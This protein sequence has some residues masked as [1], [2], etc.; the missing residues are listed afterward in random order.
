MSYFIQRSNHLSSNVH[1]CP[2]LLRC[3]W[4]TESW[5]DELGLQCSALCLWSCLVSLMCAHHCTGLYMQFHSPQD[6]PVSSEGGV[7][8]EVDRYV[9]F[10]VFPH[11]CH[12][13]D[14]SFPGPLALFL[15]VQ[16]RDIFPG[17]RG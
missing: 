5:P 6:E 4:T 1:Y 3:R 10:G 7:R 8:F 11:S 2:P 9:V 14:G 15:S 13:L 16:C 17:I 12:I